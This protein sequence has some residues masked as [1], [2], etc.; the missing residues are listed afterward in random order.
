MSDKMRE[1]FEAWV[2]RGYPKQDMGRFS[3]GE[4]QSVTINHC[5]LAW[6]A[7]REAL[8]IELPNQYDEKYQEYFDDVDGGGFNA[9][10]YLADVKSTIEAAGLKV[11]P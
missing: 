2:L 11:T 10:K 9:A 7:S 5:W 4:Y 3:D 1:E 6:G 8:V